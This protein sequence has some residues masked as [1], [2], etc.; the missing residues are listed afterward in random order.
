M[1]ALTVYAFLLVGWAGAV[2]VISSSALGT[3]GFS[4][5]VFFF[6][7]VSIAFKATL[8]WGVIRFSMEM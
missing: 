8:R 2:L 5:A 4:T 3:T 1:V 7:A 6:V